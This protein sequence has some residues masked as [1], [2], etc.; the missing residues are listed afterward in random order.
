MGDIIVS[1][2]RCGK[3]HGLETY[4][5]RVWG[6]VI[7]VS[8]P[9]CRKETV[10]NLGKF[11]EKQMFRSEKTDGRYERCHKMKALAQKIEKE[12]N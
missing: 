12:F 3:R 7:H 9:F 6:P 1:C 4:N 2:A 5:T 10:R 11:V 8:C